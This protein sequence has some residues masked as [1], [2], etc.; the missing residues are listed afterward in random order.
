MTKNPINNASLFWWGE[1]FK[2][3]QKDT[4]ETNLLKHLGWTFTWLFAWILQ[5]LNEKCS[6]W[7]PQV[8]LE[9]IFKFDVI[10]CVCVSA[11]VRRHISPLSKLPC[12][13]KHGFHC[14]KEEDRFKILKLFRSSSIIAS[15]FCMSVFGEDLNRQWTG[16]IL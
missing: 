15:A 6:L 14:K 8:I 3:V 13:G 12:C 10:V 1:Q 16:Q 9:V 2:T 11:I 4:Y 7:F 5:T